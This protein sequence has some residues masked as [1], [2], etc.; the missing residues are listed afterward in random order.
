M[1][2]DIGEHARAQVAVGGLLFCGLFA[3][4]G[5]QG[6]ADRFY[7]ALEVDADVLRPAL[8]RPAGL[9]AA[10]HLLDDRLAV[11]LHQR[12]SLGDE[13]FFESLC[14]LTCKLSRDAAVPVLTGLL[15]RWVS[16]HFVKPPDLEVDK[17]ET[18]RGFMRLSEHLAFR[19]IADW[20]KS[21]EGAGHPDRIDGQVS[22]V[23]PHRSLDGRTKD[24]CDR[25]GAAGSG[26]S[27]GSL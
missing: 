21:L 24:L 4:L 20:R 8:S 25:R 10:G 26:R 14:I 15:Q 7:E 1:V 23:V 13:P 19:D 9:T 12:S 16:A 3:S 27:P 18:R 17:P 11:A 22:Q 5:L 2:R 6:S